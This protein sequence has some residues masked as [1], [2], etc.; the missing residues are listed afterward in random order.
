MHSTLSDGGTHLEHEVLIFELN[1]FIVRM[2]DETIELSNMCDADAQKERANL[3]LPS[4]HKW[5]F[6]RFRFDL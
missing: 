5:I 1:G 2:V 6:L 4:F 3:K